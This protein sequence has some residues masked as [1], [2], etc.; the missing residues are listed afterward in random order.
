[1]QLCIFRVPESRQ[2]CNPKKKLQ[3][4]YLFWSKSTLKVRRN[5]FPENPKPIILQSVFPPR[6]T[7]PIFLQSVF[8]PRVTTPSLLQPLLSH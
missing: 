2:K 3:K 6:V 5:L 4:K 1:M 7:P 8:P